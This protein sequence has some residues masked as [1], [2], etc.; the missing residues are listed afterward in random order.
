[1]ANTRIV[2]K[3][4]D[5]LECW[6]DSDQR[7]EVGLEFISKGCRNQDRIF[8][9]DQFDMGKIEYEYHYTQADD[10]NSIAFY[11]FMQTKIAGARPIN[12][13]N[14]ESVNNFSCD[15]SVVDD[16]SLGGQSLKKKVNYCVR[17]YKRIPDLYDVFYLATSI[18][19]NNVAIMEHFT[20]SG[21]TQQSANQFLQR[22]IDTLSWN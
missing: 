6:G 21:V 22:F 16:V 18:D 20:F 14:K 12:R 13:V 9:H 8:I 10:W 5:R 2:G 17:S 7:E 19:K 3:I 15:I 4:S 11:R 1:M